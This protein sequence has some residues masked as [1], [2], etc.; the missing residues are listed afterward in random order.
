MRAA[1]LSFSFELPQRLSGSTES[2][3]TREVVYQ[4]QK[5]KLEAG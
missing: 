4:L 2:A 5:N 3:T 1:M